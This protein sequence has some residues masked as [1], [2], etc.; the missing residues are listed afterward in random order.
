MKCV[1]HN[2]EDCAECR[3]WRGPRK[4]EVNERLVPPMPGDDVLVDGRR[5]RMVEIR[6]RGG[7][8]TW[9]GQTRST[10][11]LRTGGVLTLAWDE[12]EAAWRQV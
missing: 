4:M 12:K 7:E 3:P 8:T 1:A 11:I 2:L 10:P 9:V 5:F 6:T